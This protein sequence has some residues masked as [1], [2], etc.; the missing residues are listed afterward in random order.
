MRRR[1]TFER[2]IRCVSRH[3][4]LCRAY[5]P[6]DRDCARRVYT[7]EN[8][9]LTDLALCVLAILDRKHRDGKQVAWRPWLAA[10]RIAQFICAHRPKPA[11][12]TG[13]PPLADPYLRGSERWALAG[14]DDSG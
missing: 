8:A 5:K 2:D 11:W 4:A 13:R 3:V 9:T 14:R 12:A 7:A 6:A 10:E 1:H